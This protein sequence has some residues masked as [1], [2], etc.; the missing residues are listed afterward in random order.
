MTMDDKPIV[1]CMTC[2]WNDG[3]GFCDCPNGVCT[4]DNDVYEYYKND[5]SPK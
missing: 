4:I 2:D 3:E 5:N 1:N